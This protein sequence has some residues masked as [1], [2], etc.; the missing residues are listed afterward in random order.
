MNNG[1]EDERAKEYEEMDLLL[2]MSLLER[3]RGQTRL[4]EKQA[5]KTSGPVPAIVVGSPT[6]KNA[7]G[8][9]VESHGACRTSKI[10][11]GLL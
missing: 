10:T 7:A 3:S 1:R 4:G 11:V 9:R 6:T 8:P 2:D 5:K